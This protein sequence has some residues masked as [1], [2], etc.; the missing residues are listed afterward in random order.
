MDGLHEDLNE[1]KHRSQIKI[2]D[3]D[4]LPV[5]EAAEKAWEAHQ[6]LNR[7]LIVSLFQG[8]YKSTVE[9]LHCGKQSITFDTFMYLSLPIPTPTN[10]KCVTL[11]DCLQLFLKVEKMTGAS[12]WFC[13]ACGD[14]REAEKKNGHLEVATSITYSS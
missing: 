12:K 8:Q 4:K 6:Q 3:N 13:P 10:N 9:C 2:V 11:K 7:S 5:H 1:V 14:R